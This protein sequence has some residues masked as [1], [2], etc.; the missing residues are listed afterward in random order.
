VAPQNAQC[1]SGG[2][3]LERFSCS[4]GLASIGWLWMTP[5][6]ATMHWLTGERGSV[7]RHYFWL[8]PLSL[9]PPALPGGVPPRTPAAMLI[10]RLTAPLRLAAADLRALPGAVHV[11]VIAAF[12]NPHL[13]MT[14][15][16]VVK[17]GRRLPHRPQRLPPDALD[18]ARA[19][20]HK[21]PAHCLSQALRIGGPGGSDANQQPGPSL[22]VLRRSIAARITFQCKSERA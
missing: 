6:T 4:Q 13:Q 7:M 21:G 20:R 19:G 5:L 8:L 15:L 16:T 2:W 10:P 9:S 11:A 3:I 14:T 18:S 12:T 17:P 1:L 22:Y